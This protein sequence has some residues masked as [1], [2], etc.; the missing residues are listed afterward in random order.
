[1]TTE[2]GLV[3]GASAGLGTEYAK[4]LAAD[5]AHLILVARRKD[6]L[7]ALGKQLE[8]QHGIKTWSIAADLM[9]P[10]A[11]AQVVAEVKR[12][13]L[14]VD[15]L[16]NN[17]GFG[18]SGAFVSNDAAQEVGMVNVNITALVELTR[19]LLP[20]MVERKRG[21][22]LNIGSTAGFQPGP[23]MAVYYATKAFV[24]SFTEAL[25]YELHGTGVTATVSCPGA[26]ATEFGQVAGNDKSPL[27]AM[28]A[29]GAAEV[30]LA[31]YRAMRAGAPMAVHGLKNK[32]SAFSVRLAPRG[33]VRSIAAKLNGTPTQQQLSSSAPKA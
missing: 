24:N 15:V 25:S 26:T 12:L 21:R 23:Y 2:I 6:R 30:A 31:G 20:G 18:T 33:L 7:E 1:M 3:T 8:A 10:G 32:L 5:G 14:E 4:L 16:I 11:A 17:A 29:M 27:F 19:A 9:Q 22:V 28:G 13:G